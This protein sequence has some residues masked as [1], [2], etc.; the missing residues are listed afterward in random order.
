M[1]PDAP[2]PL[3]KTKEKQIQSITSIEIDCPSLFRQLAT[4]AHTQHS[5]MIVHTHTQARAT[6]VRSPTW[7]LANDAVAGGGGAAGDSCVWL[8]PHN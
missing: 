1:I 3:R 8:G 7:T 6:Y 5:G 2:G 4:M